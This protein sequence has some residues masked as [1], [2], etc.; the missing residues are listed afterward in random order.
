MDCLQNNQCLCI[1]L[2]CSADPAGKSIQHRRE[3]RAE[4]PRSGGAVRKGG[5]EKGGMR[6]PTPPLPPAPRSSSARTL[7][8]RTCAGKERQ[9]GQRRQS[10]IQPTAAQR[11]FFPSLK[12]YQKSL[13]KYRPALCQKENTQSSANRQVFTF[14]LACFPQPLSTPASTTLCTIPAAGTGPAPEPWV[15]AG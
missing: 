3:P 1:G 8:T 10:Q 6:L 11:K 4:H 15:H 9:H 12:Q 7:E 14:L 5:C 13:G 2:H